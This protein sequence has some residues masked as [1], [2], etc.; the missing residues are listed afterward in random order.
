MSSIHTNTA[1]MTALKALQMTNSALEST[2]KNI[3]TGYRVSDASDNAAYWSIATTMRSDNKA[4]STVED[5]LGLG[6]AKIDVAYTAMDSAIDVVDEI[7]SKLVAAK[8]PGVDKTKIQSEVEALQEQLKAIADSASFSGEN[9]LAS[10]AVSGD[11]KEIVASFTRDSSGAVS[12]GTVSVDIHSSKL[13]DDATVDRTTA[14]AT[15]RGILDSTIADYDHDGDGGATTAALTYTVSIY[16][17]DITSVTDDQLDGMIVGVET[18]LETMTTAAADLGSSKS[19][20]D[21]QTEFIGN[22]MD[23]ISSGIGKLVDAD[24]TEESTRLQAL[25]TQQ[26]LGIQALSMANSGSQSLLSLFR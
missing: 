5:A 26:Q 15:G 11:T 21:M 9:W 2:Q 13:F 14:S 19:R 6:A 25:Q 1:A 4:L 7:K 10:S 17:L 12:I 22:L 23:S 3:S 24:M 18:A 20:I 8:E 16:N